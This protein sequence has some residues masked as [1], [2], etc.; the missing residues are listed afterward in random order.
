L[1]EQVRL[2][3]GGR[4]QTERQ[5][6]EAV[7]FW[8]IESTQRLDDSKFTW[9]FGIDYKLSP[10]NLVYGLISTGWKNGGTN[11]GALNGAINVPTEFRP[12]EVTSFEIGSR[13]SLADESVR[14]NISA[15]FNDYE[16]LQF[17]EEDPVP[18]AGG[19][20]NIPGTQIYGIETEITW[21]LADS[22]QV[23]GQLTW[24]D[25]TFTEDFTTL[26]VVDFREALAPG[27]GLFTPAGFDVRLDLSQNTNLKGNI[28]PKLVD[29]S[30]RLALTNS[31]N[32]DN[33]ATLVSRLEFV[34]RGNYQYRVFNNP[35]VDAVPSYAIINLLFRYEFTKQDLSVGVA[36][37][38]LLDEAGVNSRFSNPFGLL[39]T[40]EEYIPPRE[41]F[42]T[43][44][45]NF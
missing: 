7:Q 32:F 2:I 25:G 28:P 44:R 29:W 43:L 42:V 8:D 27:V 10:S 24:M 6:D 9:K 19:T 17:M 37:T 18:F 45:Y 35:L 26:D 13:N 39:T 31:R 1:N 30:A 41:V 3:A 14:L 33:N 23:D 34:Y 21:L 16:N 4:Y 15:F 22:W 40:S 20:G 36:A 38:N 12:A 11:P 5:L